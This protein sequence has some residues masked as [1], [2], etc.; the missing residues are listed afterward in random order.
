MPSDGKR[1]FAVSAPGKVLFSGGY[2]V[3][4]REHTGLVFGLDARIHV[5]I[6]CLKSSDPS[7]AAQLEVCSPQFLKAKWAYT[8]QRK[9]EPLL[10]TCPDV[11]FFH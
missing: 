6:Q 11:V 4:D 9:L 2:L 7:P 3:L 8:Y 10:G 1:A 5:H